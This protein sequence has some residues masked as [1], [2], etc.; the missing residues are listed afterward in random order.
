MKIRHRQRGRQGLG[1]ITKGKKGGGKKR[2]EKRREGREGGGREVQGEVSAPTC[3]FSK[4]KEGGRRYDID[5]E[6]DKA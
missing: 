3:G 4:K 1:V 6:G 2:E 5:R